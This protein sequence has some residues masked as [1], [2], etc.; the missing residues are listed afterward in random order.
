MAVVHQ[1]LSR[2]R[3]GE[4]ATES[5]LRLLVLLRRLGH[6]GELLALAPAPDAAP[7][8]RR[9]ATVRLR[10]TDWVLG[11]HA[12]ASPLSARLLLLGCQR[13]LVLDA[14]PAGDV[15][16]RAQLA[17]LA[18]TMAFSLAP[19][20]AAASALRVAGHARVSQF[21]PFV[22]AERF[23]EARADP[24]L[25]GQLRAGRP[26]IVSAVVS[27]ATPQE[28]LALHTE[29]V[30]LRPDARLL[31]LGPLGGSANE[32][33]AFQRQARALPGL[34]LLGERSHAE[35]V[36]T[37][38]SAR[39]F[40]SLAEGELTGSQLLEAMA[41]DVPVLAYAAGAVPEVLAGAG[42]A[43]TEK[44]YAFLAEMIVQLAE[45]K[46]LRTR[47]LAGQKRRLGH[48]TPAEAES[49]LR[50]ALKA[51]GLN[52]ERSAVCRRRR[53]RVAVVVQRYGDVTGG[54]EALARSVVQR[55]A[56]RWEMTVLTTCAKDHLSWENAFP[57]GASVMDGVPVQRFATRIPRDMT[58]FNALSRR[59]FGRSLDRGEEERWLAMQ[60]PLVPGLWRHLAEEGQRYDGFLAFTYLYASTAWSIPLAGA[61][62]ILVP[63]AHDEPPLAF[64]CYRDVFERPGALFASTPE[65]LNLISRR[66]PGHARA[67]VVGAGVEPPARVDPARFQKRFKVSRPY[68]LYVGRVEAGKGIPELLAF[69]ASLRR[70]EPHAPDLLLAGDASLTVDA[71]GVRALGR[72]PERDKWD[73]LAGALAVVVPSRLESLSLLA[74]EAF[75][76]GTPVVGNGDSDVVRGQLERSGA[77][78][79][80]WD[81]SSFRE[82]VK[83]V[84]R[85]RGTFGVNG[86]AYARKHRWTDVVQAYREEMHR[87]LEER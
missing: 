66:F 40:L 14:Q 15:G 43:F 50:V 55:L 11:H 36:A 85:K 18:E 45:D 74:L 77:G 31:S 62:T 87:L 39:L 82:A 47:V 63:T 6:W 78:R 53:P 73:A 46:R 67:R 30:R 22:E 38:R 75:A 33:R 29:L 49:S 35:R 65:E 76:L 41:S 57:P 24:R 25:L 5:A 59:L 61:R 16:S 21:S 48:A 79:V 52:E 23:T 34:W 69:F 10:R 2:F 9:L 7:L 83:A 1:L 12:G 26:D 27:G 56:S 84:S 28:L 64:G 19:S 37:L 81:A 80:Y 8:V 13:A 86:R 72:I 51:S 58:S 60:G 17:A 44:R 20:A 3:R 42:V 32:L 4:A 54:A 68:L 70:A 71:P